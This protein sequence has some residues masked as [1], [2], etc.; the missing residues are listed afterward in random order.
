MSGANFCD[1][2]SPDIKYTGCRLKL[3]EGRLGKG[4]LKMIVNALHYVTPQ[5]VTVLTCEAL[6]RTSCLI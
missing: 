3:W 6:Q 2:D 5:L 1:V 4:K